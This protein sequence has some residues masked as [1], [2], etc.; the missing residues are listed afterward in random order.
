MKIKDILKKYL[1]YHIVKEITEAMKSQGRGHEL[2]R[3]NYAVKSP[4]SIIGLSFEW[5]IKNYLNKNDIYKDDSDFQD[6]IINSFYNQHNEE[7]GR[8]DVN[9]NP[10][11]DKLDYV[12]NHFE[13]F[14]QYAQNNWRKIK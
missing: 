10:W 4:H 12:H 13:L 8:L 11:K 6:I 5:A 1:P 7:E 2:N 9:D 3:F 14:C